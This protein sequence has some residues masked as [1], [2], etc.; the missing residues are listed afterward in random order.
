MAGP[1]LISGDE[2]ANKAASQPNPAFSVAH[3]LGTRWAAPLANVLPPVL[4]SA[5]SSFEEQKGVDVISATDVVRVSL[6][7]PRNPRDSRLLLALQKREAGGVVTMEETVV[8]HVV[9]TVRIGKWSLF[10]GASL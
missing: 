7:D 3:F 4:T 2:K 1:R 5:I 6:V 10:G 8:D 9:C